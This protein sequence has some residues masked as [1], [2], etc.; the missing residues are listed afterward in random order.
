MS[1]VRRDGLV[2][3]QKGDRNDVEGK[4]PNFSFYCNKAMQTVI[5]SQKK[6]L[7]NVWSRRRRIPTNLIHEGSR[8]TS[9]R[10]RIKSRFPSLS[11]LVV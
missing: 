8:L 2:E 5:P 11:S 4:I 9:A 3:D 7:A 10:S 1:E 6:Q